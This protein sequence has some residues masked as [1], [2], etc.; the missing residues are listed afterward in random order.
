LRQFTLEA[1]ATVDGCSVVIYV[2]GKVSTQPG[3]YG[4]RTPAREPAPGDSQKLS[5]VAYSIVHAVVRS[6]QLEPLGSFVEMVAEAIEP[7]VAPRLE[8]AL[9]NV[10]D[11]AAAQE[12]A[13]EKRKAVE[14]TNRAMA[15]DRLYSFMESYPYSRED[16]I[17]A[18][19]LAQVKQV[20]ES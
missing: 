7:D 18:W 11:L 20:M 15:K 8:V 3:G 19:E 9:Q 12:R 17:A 10:V 2:R 13:G 14:A 16:V 5:T 4:Y 6:C 1:R